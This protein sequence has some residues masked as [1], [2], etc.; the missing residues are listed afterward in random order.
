LGPPGLK[1]GET[2]AALRAQDAYLS[3]PASVGGRAKIEL[4]RAETLIRAG[5]V[6]GGARYCVTVLGALPGTWRRERDI[7]SNARAALGAVP[8]GLVSRRSVREAR[9]VLALPPGRV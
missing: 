3:C 2:R 5:D 7:A 9:E 4:L 8:A 6:D 1:V